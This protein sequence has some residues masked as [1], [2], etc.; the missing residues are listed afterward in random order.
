[1]YIIPGHPCTAEQPEVTLLKV[2]PQFLAV[3]YTA[4]VAVT[5]GYLAALQLI[6]H[7]DQAVIALLVAGSGVVYG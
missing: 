5:V 2:S 6:N 1:M 7:I 3:G 4:Y